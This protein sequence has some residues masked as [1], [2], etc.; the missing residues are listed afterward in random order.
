MSG[1]AGIRS[2]SQPQA[3][4]ALA[5]KP[6]AAA[7]PHPFGLQSQE[8]QRTHLSAK[9]LWQVTQACRSPGG[10]SAPA[11]FLAGQHGL[12]GV[13]VTDIPAD[14]GMIQS[15]AVFLATATGTF[16]QL[17]RAHLTETH[18]Q[19]CWVP[20][21]EI[22]EQFAPI[23]EAGGAPAMLLTLKV[24][25]SCCW[26]KLKSELARLV[27]A[28]SNA[29]LRLLGCHS[30]DH[31]KGV[32]KQFN[33]YFWLWHAVSTAYAASR[34]QPLPGQ[35]TWPRTSTLSCP[36]GSTARTSPPSSRTTWARPGRAV[37]SNPRCR[38][39]SHLPQARA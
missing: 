10:G 19:F 22:V 13:K 18:P 16:S 27:E 28:D 11:T 36:R 32:Q 39:Y 29:L 38:D 35:K 1:S 17:H 3:S 31:L 26:P 5:A 8:N 4:G 23:L 30:D 14:S 15:L 21:V 6:A 24:Q 7:E 37:S 12:S 9:D 34:E 2:R 25:E 20:I 33:G